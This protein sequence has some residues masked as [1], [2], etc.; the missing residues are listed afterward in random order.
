MRI[1]TVVSATAAVLLASCSGDT[2]TRVV[3]PSSTPATRAA[4]VAIVSG[5]KQAAKAGEPLSEPLV[6]R[7]TDARG[8]GV[9][10][11]SVLFEISG[12]GGLDGKQAPGDPRV[13]THTRADGTAQVVLE[14]YDLGPISVTARVEGTSLAPVTFTADVAV[15][16]VEFH[17]PAAAGAYAAFWGPC[18]C[19]RTINTVAVPV[20]TPVEWATLDSTPYTITSVSSPAPAAAFES[21]TLGRSS[22]FRFVPTVPGT[23]EY[24]DRF[25]GLRA[26]L[27][28]R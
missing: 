26:T 8:Q 7:V 16:V 24:E 22:R 27:T 17:S 18:R 10:M 23:W 9:E 28:A 21:G 25:S 14:P 5:D 2:E 6:V 1:G 15:V 19:A 3:A 13:S 4:A 12:S 20:G 11:A